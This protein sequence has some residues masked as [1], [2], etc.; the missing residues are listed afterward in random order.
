M[1]LEKIAEFEVLAE[2]VEALVAAEPL[3]LGRMDA[4]LHAGGER[5]ALEALAVEIA[6]PGAGRHSAGLDEMCDGLRRDR[7]GADPG[8]GRGAAWRQAPLRAWREPN[9]PK[10][11]AVAE[12]G[13]LQPGL[14]GVH[15]TEFGVAVGQGNRHGVGLLALAVR[16]GQPDAAV[17]LFQVREADRREFRPPQRAGKADQQ[18]GAVAETAQVAW[19][20]RQQPAMP[21]AMIRF[22]RKRSLFRVPVP[23]TGAAALGAEQSW[24][25]DLWSPA[26]LHAIERESADGLDQLY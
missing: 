2:H 25:L 12:A 13:S 15:G 7:A 1:S 8:Q 5:A 16:Q 17:G 18:E 9:T 3:Q 22:S 23:L 10:Q 4:A 24:E 21:S 20:R 26:F 11:R 6:R 19:D 14:Q